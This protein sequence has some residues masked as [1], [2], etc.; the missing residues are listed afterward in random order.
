MKVLIIIIAYIFPLAV[1]GQVERGE[2]WR[3]IILHTQLLT[4]TMFEKLIETQKA[5]KADELPT[6]LERALLIKQVNS[7]KI[8]GH[9]VNFSSDTLRIRQ[10]GSVPLNYFTEVNVGNEWIVFQTFVPAPCGMGFGKA[11]LYPFHYTDFE[12][13]VKT[14][15]DIKLPYRISVETENGLIHSNVVNISCSKKQFRKMS[16]PIRP[17]TY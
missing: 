4:D 16:K 17:L 10:N 9:I 3:Y 12:V 14:R 8:S 6:T 13:E 2:H 7:I 5:I 1:F 15:G 11:N